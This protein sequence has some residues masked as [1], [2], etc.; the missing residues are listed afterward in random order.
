MVTKRGK[1]VETKG[2]ALP[3]GR[4]AD[5]EDN[6]KYLGVP[7]AHSNH[8]KATRE[9]ATAEYLQRVRQVLKTQLNGKK[10]IKAING[11][12]LPVIL[13]F[14]DKKPAKG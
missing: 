4:K 1:I 6:Y 5:I 9:A 13:P 2:I 3:E 14:W 12:A 8:K 11:Y 10:R 7:Q